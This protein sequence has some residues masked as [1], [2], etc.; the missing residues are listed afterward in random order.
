MMYMKHPSIQPAMP[1]VKATAIG[2]SLMICAVGSALAQS[3]QV[4]ETA[5]APGP[6][7]PKSEKAYPPV[8]VTD[9]PLEYRQ[10]E[11]VE[12][13]GSAILA[14]EAKQALPLQ[15][16]ERREIERSGA[17]SL[18]ELIQRL[19]V[20]SNF[21]ELGSVTGTVN[22]GPEAAAIHGN[23][24][25][26][27]VLLNGRRLPYYGSQ[28]IMSERSV[29]DLNLVPLAAIEK[30]EI[31]TDGASSRYGSDAVAG[32]IN[33]IT[34]SEYR[35]LGI[36]VAA[37][38]PQGG[39]GAGQSV[40]LSWG[41][42]RLQRDG[43]NVRGYFMAE[44]K[45]AL[46]AGQRD[47]ASQGARSVEIDGKTWW[48][49]FN[50]SP[51]AAPA[52]NY[53]DVNGVLRNDHFERTGQCAPG[54]LELYRGR[55]DR[56]TQGEMT[57]YPAINKQILYAQADKVLPNRWVLFAEG[58][59]GQQNQTT[60]PSGGY[61]YRN[62]DNA[63]QSRSYL[64]DFEPLGLTTQKYTN[65]IQNGVLGLRGEQFGWDFL[66][67]L[68]AG[69]HKVHR[70]YVGGSVKW[71][72]FNDTLPAS[73]ITQDPAQYSAQTLAQLKSYQW[74]K[75]VMD[76][77]FSRLHSFSVLA[78][79]EWIETDN[80]PV[81]VGVGLDWRREQV[82][83][84]APTYTG[85]PSFGASR[86]NWASHIEVHAP[87]GETTEATAALRHDQYSD[88]GSVQ[89]GK[90]GW[91]WKPHAKWLFRGSV[92]TG[93]RAPS[94]GQLVPI[95]TSI[96]AI[97]DQ[98]TGDTIN[99]INQGNP[100]LQPEHSVQKTLGIRFEPSQRL[101]LGVD[102]WQVD[103]RDTFGVL[104][105]TDILNKPELRAR[106]FANGEIIQSNQNLGQSVKRGL[107]YDIQVRQPTEWG[108]VRVTWRGML[109]LKASTRDDE[110]A[111]SVSNLGLSGGGLTSTTARH[112]WAMSTLLE[113]Q[114]WTMG[115]TLHYRSSEQEKTVLTDIDGQQI[116]HARRIPAYWT[117]DLSSRWQIKPQ[118]SLSL[119]VVNL[120]NRLPPL[121]LAMY[122]NVILGVDTRYGNYW[123]RNLQ[124]R[125][126]HKF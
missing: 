68:S 94:M 48:N 39:H 21:S 43:Y 47:V 60:V 50:F 30:I 58:L 101:S 112:Q 70:A 71:E 2:L 51:S 65:R 11:K 115:M 44:T 66:T 119:S 14:K 117:V 123:G 90:L 121:R 93:F 46:L 116:D 120:E 73:L 61:T 97:S 105:Y 106:F 49:K 8:Q 37:T 88:F 102:L 81:N 31:L 15:V 63:D 107:D 113:R 111:V 17:A 59:L 10:F 34:K 13:T 25:G 36:G 84:E 118:T 91:K 62:V 98:V 108:R 80:G 126:D 109:M 27:L 103:I 53:Y 75:E 32:V 125:L 92:G 95:K 76:D 74:G 28:T 1:W 9:S 16:I 22:G 78:S 5:A 20:M 35:G 124:I 55:C 64:L 69:R 85:R 122:N 26:T 23:Q 87:L 45:E 54:W 57:L 33:I 18:P 38:Q 110:T 24:S 79:R 86:Y 96:A 41:Q 19:P 72:L 56:N 6:T 67:S 114:D 40:S 100:Q 12:I 104:N 77:G 4:T 42:G 89:T 29:V 99:I 52:Q 83:Y 82:G 7:V 3:A